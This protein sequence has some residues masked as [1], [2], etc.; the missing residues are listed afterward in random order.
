MIS[1]LPSSR[2]AE[3]MLFTAHPR[4]KPQILTSA[5]PPAVTEREATI[6]RHNPVVV[7]HHNLRGQ[8]SRTDRLGNN[9]QFGGA[10]W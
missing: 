3:V 7:S 1:R 6:T 8:R 10:G 4:G 2:S 9:A 5:R